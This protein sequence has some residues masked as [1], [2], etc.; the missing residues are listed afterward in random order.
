MWRK[1]PLGLGSMAHERVRKKEREKQYPYLT[2]S[3]LRLVSPL[4]SLSLSP[5]ITIIASEVVFGGS[6]ARPRITPNHHHFDRIINLSMNLTFVSFIASW[7][8][9]NPQN[10]N[11]TITIKKKLK[12]NLKS[13]CN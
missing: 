11:Q 13:L 7:I 2:L 4:F 9:Y 10:Q 3:L 12:L 5:K 1:R 8:S 6:V